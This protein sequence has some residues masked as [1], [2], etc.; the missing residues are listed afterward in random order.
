MDY[1]GGF[2]CRDIV[3]EATRSEGELKEAEESAG[4]LERALDSLGWALEA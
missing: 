4:N 3:W 1:S 2:E